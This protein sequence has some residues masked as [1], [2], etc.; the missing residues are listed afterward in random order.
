M[1]AAVLRPP[2]KR[3]TVAE[4]LA[5]WQAEGP[6][7]HLPTCFQSLNRATGGGPVFGSRWYVMGAP[8]ASKTLLLT[9]LAH[10]WSDEGFTVGM[11][12]VDEEDQDLVT[13][14][15]QRTPIPRNGG[16]HFSRTQCEDRDESDLSLMRE[17]LSFSH[18][19]FYGE[20][21]TIEDAAED[22]ALLAAE[23]GHR[24]ILMVDS[25]QTVSCAGTKSLAKDAGVREKITANVRAIRAS[26]T[27]HKML[28]MATS[29]MNR[30]A[31]KAIG[32]SEQN[33]MAAAKESGAVEYSARVMLALRNVAD[34]PNCIEA[35]VVK[36]KHGP[37]FPYLE[38]FYM[39]IDRARQWLDERPPPEAG[40]SDVEKAVAVVLA[41][42]H[43][44]TTEDVR[45]ALGRKRER[46][47]AALSSA[48][49]EG[50][51]RR[52][53][54]SKSPW[55]RV[56]PSASAIDADSDEFP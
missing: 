8:D 39:K 43:G 10:M 17:A 20:E 23:Q 46:V 45:K 32:A 3:T 35:R 52:L 25:I 21:C 56:E 55:V 18:I 30:A 12:A 50:S 37:S 51:I 44:A 6:L 7:V 13:R 5:R 33:D 31:Y 2:I 49:A 15:V 34:E 42:P 28:I 40:P 54:G 22:L 19:V 9:Q 16:G 29:E 36:N 41:S 24:A 11:L 48:A 47:E 53:N 27:K 1:I 26:A 14:I 4:V 38:P